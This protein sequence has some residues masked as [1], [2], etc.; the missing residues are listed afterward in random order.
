MARDSSSP[1]DLRTRA[2]SGD[3]V[4]FVT[5]AAADPEVFGAI[6]DRYLSPVYKYCFRR[7]PTTEDAEDATSLIFAKALAT[8][9]HQREARAVRSWLFTIATMSLPTTTAL[10]GRRWT[11]PT[12]WESWTPQVRRK[13]ASSPPRNCGRSWCGSRPT[14][15]ASSSCDWLASPARRSRESSARARRLSRLRNSAPIQPPELVGTAHWTDGGS[16]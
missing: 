6:Y 8:L 16:Q 9:S 11:S 15:R 3:P 1:V 7:L 14:R 10:D 5:T 4:G 13:H 2:P 12:P